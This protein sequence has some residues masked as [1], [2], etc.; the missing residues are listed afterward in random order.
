MILSPKEQTVG[1]AD[2]GALVCLRPVSVDSIVLYVCNLIVLVVPAPAW[3]A[4]ALRS[5]SLSAGSRLANISRLTL[6][7]SSYCTYI[8]HKKCVLGI[9][10]LL[11]L[12]ELVDSGLHV[13]LTLL[14][15]PSQRAFA[16]A[17]SVRACIRE[18]CV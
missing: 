9:F 7:L 18:P 11:H 17:P 5:R 8:N 10:V 14:R 12:I 3:G 1:A 2:S 16:S 15:R 4:A 6:G 13:N